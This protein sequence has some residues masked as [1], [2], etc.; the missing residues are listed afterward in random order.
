MQGEGYSDHGLYTKWYVH[1]PLSR[2]DIGTTVRRI[3]YSEVRNDPV[4]LELAKKY[5]ATPTQVIL[6]WHIYRETIIVPKSV[7][8]ERQ[9][10]NITVRRACFT[11]QFNNPDPGRLFVA[12]YARGRGLGE[13]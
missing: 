10:E 2:T 3:G 4:I 1:S 6:A 12:D 7:N 11:Q 8:S 13:D 5:N 9:K